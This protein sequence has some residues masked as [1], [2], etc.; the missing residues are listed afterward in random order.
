MLSR[1]SLRLKK[2]LWNLDNTPM[3]LLLDRIT[4]SSHFRTQVFTNTQDAVKYIR[5]SPQQIKTFKQAMKDVVAE[6]QRFLCGETPT[7][8]NSTF[9][10]LRSTY[11]VKDAF[12]EYSHQGFVIQCFKKSVERIPSHFD[13]EMIKNMMEF[14]EKFKKKTGKVSSSTKPIFHTYTREILDIE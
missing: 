13:F 6:T 7:R 2:I 1:E 8:W 14:L 3:N 5:A 4:P 9:E 10:L 11:D 12:L